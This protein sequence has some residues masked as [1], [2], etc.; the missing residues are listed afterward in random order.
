M[1]LTDGSYYGASFLGQRMLTT[2]TYPEYWKH[3]GNSY[4]FRWT[5]GSA[6]APSDAEAI[7][8]GKA[9]HQGN[10]NCLFADGHVKTLN[11]DRV[12]VD[13]SL[14]RVFAGQP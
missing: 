11:Y 4:L 10:L 3:L 12:R 9:R 8:L 6:Q 7:Q 5:G 1:I 2:T 14:W 13:G